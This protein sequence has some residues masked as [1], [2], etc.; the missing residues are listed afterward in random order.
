[1]IW[2]RSDLHGLDLPGHGVSLWTRYVCNRFLLRVI[3]RLATEHAF[4]APLTPAHKNPPARQRVRPCRGPRRH[5]AVS[6]PVT[7]HT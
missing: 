2:D 1:M 7:W 3:R 4:P 5:A 6:R